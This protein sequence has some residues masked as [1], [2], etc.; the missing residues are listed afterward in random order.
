M[1]RKNNRKTIQQRAIESQLSDTLAYG[2]YGL[3]LNRTSENTFS[4][5]GVEADAKGKRD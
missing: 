4:N 2:N 3:G 1:G 5:K